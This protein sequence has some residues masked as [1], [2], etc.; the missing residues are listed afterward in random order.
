MT[1]PDFPLSPAGIARR[2]QILDLAKREA[3]KR[4]LRRKTQSA[5]IVFALALAISATIFQQ[6]HYSPPQNAPIVLSPSPPTAPPTNNVIIRFIT[7]DPTIATRLG[8][9]SKHRWH[10]IGDDELIQL[11]AD[12]GHPSGIIHTAHQTILL[13]RN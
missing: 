6:Y 7:T 2:E 3:R 4:N 13:P 12:A 11:L 5:L 8:I 10:R 9:H 1:D